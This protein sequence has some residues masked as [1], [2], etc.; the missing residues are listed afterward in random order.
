MV[1]FDRNADSTRVCCSYDTDPHVYALCVGKPYVYD[2]IIGFHPDIKQKITLDVLLTIWMREDAHHSRWLF[3][4]KF[5]ITMVNRITKGD[6]PALIYFTL[7][8]DEEYNEVH[9]KFVNENYN[10]ETQG[11]LNDLWSIS[12]CIDDKTHKQLTY[13]VDEVSQGTYRCSE[14]RDY[15]EFII[16]H[17]TRNFT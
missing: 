17:I 10:Y 1:F 4:D 5:D 15:Q 16:S 3:V 13:W 12:D 7:K 2:E 14:Y 11:M 6:I 9:I 8:R